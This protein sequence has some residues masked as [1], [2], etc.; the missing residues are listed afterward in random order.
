MNTS[1]RRA[2]LEDL[3]GRSA[4]SF[5][6]LAGRL[7]LACFLS[8]WVALLPAV[9]YG[10]AL[11]LAIASSISFALFAAFGCCWVHGSIAGSRVVSERLGFRVGLLAGARPD[12]WRA[13]IERQRREHDAAGRAPESNQVSEDV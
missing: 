4:A 1:A 5:L 8:W 12:A 11:E 2:E 7:F 10:T 9:L 3:I 6:V 13:F